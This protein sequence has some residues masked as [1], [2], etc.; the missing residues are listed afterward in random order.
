MGS[1]LTSWLCSWTSAQ[2]AHDALAYAHEE[3]M[4]DTK[5]AALAG[6]LNGANA[7]AGD[8]WERL[9]GLNLTWHGAGLR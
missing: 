9:H 2:E 8:A 5:H 3:L 6:A 7:S 1:D 4:Q